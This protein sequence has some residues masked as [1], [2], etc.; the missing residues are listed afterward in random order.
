MRIAGFEMLVGM[1]TAV[2]PHLK[3]HE[4][5]GPQKGYKIAGIARLEDLVSKMA[6]A[7]PYLTSPQ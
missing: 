7:V 2:A 6:G 5:V 4:H 1:T 3:S